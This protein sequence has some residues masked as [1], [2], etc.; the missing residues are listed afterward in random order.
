MKQ[1]C[2]V[3]FHS[4][5]QKKHKQIE[6]VPGVKVE[7][8]YILQQLAR[9]R[10]SRSVFSSLTVTVLPLRH[11]KSTDTL[12]LD[13][14]RCRRDKYCF[15]P[16]RLPFHFFSGPTRCCCRRARALSSATLRRPRR[17]RSRFDNND[18]SWRFAPSPLKNERTTVSSLL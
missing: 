1:L 13:V 6:N 10:K 17:R 9:W 8:S 7:C 2:G 11:F 15:A 5:P 18:C 16:F 3:S 14:P 12:T 4:N